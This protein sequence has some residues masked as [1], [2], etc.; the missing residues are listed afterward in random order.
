MMRWRL[1]TQDGS[2]GSCSNVE[3]ARRCIDSV[4]AVDLEEFIAY[5]FVRSPKW[6][7]SVWYP[8]SSYIGV[9]ESGV[10]EINLDISLIIRAIQKV[11]SL[12]TL[13]SEK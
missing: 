12:H 9:R 10:R 6:N 8:T 3:E 1:D 13:E 4:W 7:V 11:L 2:A 5:R